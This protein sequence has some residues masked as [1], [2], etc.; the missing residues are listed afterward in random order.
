MTPARFGAYSGDPLLAELALG[1][2]VAELGPARRVVLF[3]DEPCLARLLGE[4]VASDLFG[5]A[6]AIV[7]RR[8]DTLVGEKR[9]AAALARGLPPD[10][11]LYFLGET[12]K[13][14]VATMAEEAQHFPTPT[15]RALRTLATRLLAEADLPQPPFVVDLLVEAAGGDTLRL[16]QEV[17]KLTLWKGARLT[18]DQLVEL[19]FF[20]QSAPYAYLDAVGTGELSSALAELR[21]LLNSGWNP[22]ALFFTLVGHVRALLLAISASQEGRTAPGPAWLVRRRLAQARVWGEKRLIGL[23]VSLQ[24][25]DLRIKTGLL[26]PE[27]ALHLFTLRLASA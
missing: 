8:A 7:V 26:S 14:P 25:L 22:A 21:A 13:G 19:L 4:L 10:L 11:A 5:E 6:R 20:F 9:L 12:L 2:A 16:A 3:G 27:A 15:G 24:E 1:Q 18:R 23:L 17:R